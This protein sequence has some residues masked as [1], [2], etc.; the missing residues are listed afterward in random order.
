MPFALTYHFGDGTAVSQLFFRQLEADLGEIESAIASGASQPSSS[1]VMIN[2]TLV[3]SVAGN[4]LTI[5]IKTLAGADPSTSDQVVIVFR[6]PTA[7]TGNFVVRTITAATSLVISSG[8]TLGVANNTP[9][10]VW[11]VGLDD[12]GTFRLGAQVCT[13]ANAMYPLA[14]YS[15]RSSVAEGGAGAADSA[16]VIYTGTAVTAKS[17]RILGF[18]NWSSGLVAA[19]TWASGPTK[20]QLFGGGV[21]KP[22]D[23]VQAAQM[24][25]GSGTTTSSTW[26]ATTLLVTM[27]PTD[28]CNPVSISAAY[29]IDG[30]TGG[31]FYYTSIQRG[32]SIVGKPAFL[33]TAAGGETVFSI[34]IIFTDYPAVITSQTWTV[35]IRNNNNVATMNAFPD[36][37]V[38]AGGMLQ[39]WE[40]MG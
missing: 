2:G 28:E 29:G 25:G 20:I 34:P 14:E 7:A 18:M 8:S 1:D 17:L 21:P 30:V 23:T 33:Y 38:G 27:T 4:A 16:G 24:T 6:N 39:A 5:A 19:G 15:L 40:I 9:F 26:T 11:I 10:R 37:G 12:A 32:G 35:Y 13:V 3:A 36:G 31:V 22:G